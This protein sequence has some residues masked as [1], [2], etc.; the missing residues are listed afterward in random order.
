MF[1]ATE[2]HA[3][4]LL[5]S[6]CRCLHFGEAGGKPLLTIVR[7]NAKYAQL[8]CARTE[9]YLIN[10]NVALTSQERIDLLSGP[11]EELMRR[12]IGSKLVL[13]TRTL[14]VCM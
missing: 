3:R 4:R 1:Q 11:E 5:V 14:L 13:C 9:G 10:A 7:L 6:D 12:V 8:F 2:L